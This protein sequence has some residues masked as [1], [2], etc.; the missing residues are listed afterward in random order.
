MATTLNPPLAGRAKKPQPGGGGPTGRPPGRGDWGG[1][2]DDGRPDFRDRL[3]R[4]RIGMIVGLTPILMLFVAFTSAYIVR[5]GLGTWDQQ[6]NA[7]VSDWRALALPPLL[8]VNTVILLASS[9]TLEMAR[10]SLGM[11]LVLSEARSAGLPIRNREFPW[12]PVT[13]V[14]GFAFLAGQATAWRQLAARGVYMSTNPSSSFFYLLTGAHAV[15]LLGGLVALLV[16]ALAAVRSDSWQRRR[17]VVDVT[18]WYWHFMALLWLY[19]F[20]LLHFAK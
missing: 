1:G 15:H 4:Y 10:R 12:L 18:S 9:L 2:G 6:T 7:Y 19:I 14:L 5:Q 20:A 11:G 3:R 17:L 8:W 16:A 13:V